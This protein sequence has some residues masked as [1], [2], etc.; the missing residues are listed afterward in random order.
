MSLLQRRLEQKKTDKPKA[1]SQIADGFPALQ[2]LNGRLVSYEDNFQ[3]Y[4][5]KG[6]NI[7][8]I[9]YS[10]V[11]MMIDKAGMTKWGIYKVQDEDAYKKLRCE[12]SQKEINFKRISDLHHKALVPNPNAGKWGDLLMNTNDEQDFSELFMEAFAFLLITGNQYI[13]G[14]PLKGGANAGVPNQLW[15]QAADRMTIW[16]DG[17]FPTRKTGYTNTIYNVNFLP[18]TI[19][20]NKYPNLTYDFNGNQLYGMSPLKAGLKRLQKSNSQLTAETA[21]WDNEGIKGVFA[22]KTIP[23]QV[24]P[25]TVQA[26]LVEPFTQ[27][28]R[29]EWQGAKNRRRMGVSGYDLDWIPVGLNADEMELIASGLVDLRMMC[30]WYG[31]PSQLMN[32]PEN[33]IYSNQKEGEKAFTSR[34]VISQMCKFRDAFIRFAT[35]N[36]SFP[37]GNVLDFDITYYPELQND[38]KTVVEATNGLIGVIPNEQREQGGLGA[39]QDPI[40]NEPWVIQN[41]QR[42]PLSEMMA[43]PVDQA[44]NDANNVQEDI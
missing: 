19:F 20:H 8:D 32:D 15:N 25:E 39:L 14:D 3:N 21:S 11:K 34:C 13:W 28:M 1:I 26:N 42:V 9:L 16:S 37:K 30:N 18:E 24:D 17:R 43:S 35:K 2:I 12:Q 6:Y 44:L 40:F 7:N 5:L 36:W 4:I 29:T 38:I 10:L 41:G 22:F 31:V 23:G 27:T 33:K